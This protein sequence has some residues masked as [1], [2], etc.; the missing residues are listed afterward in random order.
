MKYRL[1]VLLGL[2][3]VTEI[4]IAGGANADNCKK[5]EIEISLLEY[6]FCENKNNIEIL[7]IID[8]KYTTLVMQA[9]NQE[10]SFAKLPVS[11]SLLDIPNKLNISLSEFFNRLANRD[12]KANKFPEIRKAFEIDENTVIVKYKKKRFKA[13][14]I[15]NPKVITNSIYIYNDDKSVYLLKGKFNKLFS[16]EFLA[17][18]KPKK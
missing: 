11:F 6:L 4:A 10:Y 7:N 9:K 15:I 8:G 12:Y 5:N 16:D 3:L 2:I 14:A 17:N 1:F 18:L 13:V